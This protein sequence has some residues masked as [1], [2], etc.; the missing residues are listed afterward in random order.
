MA[1][2]NTGQDAGMGWIGAGAGGCFALALW[3]LAAF[4]VTARERF[5]RLA[6]W[7]FVAFGV[8][9]TIT[10]VAAA[11]ALPSSGLGAGLT[12]IGA[13][14]CIGLGIAE[15]GV[16]LRLVEFRR[17]EFAVTVAFVAVLAWIAGTSALALANERPPVGLGWLGLAG[18]ATGALAVAATARG[19]PGSEGGRSVATLLVALPPLVAIAAWMGWLGASL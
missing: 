10:V 3:L 4:L 13:A 1:P 16:T 9:G 17:V 7:F 15:L 6:E 12:L 11:A 18:L 19:G 5:D 2:S 14:G 8:L